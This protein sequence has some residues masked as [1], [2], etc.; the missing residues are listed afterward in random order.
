MPSVAMVVTD[1][2][3][4]PLK[5]NR[6]DPKNGWSRTKA[7]RAFWMRGDTGVLLLLVV[8]TVINGRTSH[9]KLAGIRGFQRNALAR[10]L[11]IARIRRATSSA[12]QTKLGLEC[13]LALR[14]NCHTIGEIADNS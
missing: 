11:G 10:V 9:R 4:F 8:T 7:V 14:G 13:C 2:L 5:R 3:S 6:S 1:R 12:F